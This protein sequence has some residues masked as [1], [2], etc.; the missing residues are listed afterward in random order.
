MLS[1]AGGSVQ[2]THWILGLGIAVLLV[3]VLTS[4]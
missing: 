2:P 1:I 3:Q 4:Q